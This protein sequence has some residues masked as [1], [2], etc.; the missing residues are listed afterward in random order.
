MR[1]GQQNRKG[2]S[3]ALLL[4]PICSAAILLLLLPA[5]LRSVHASCGQ[6]DDFRWNK[7]E[8]APAPPEPADNP[9][10]RVK[11]QLGRRL[12]YDKRLS[13]DGSLSCATCHQQSHAFT[14]GQPARLGVDGKLGIRNAMTLTNVAYLP[15]YTWANPLITSLECQMQVPLFGE[16]PVEMGMTGHER[17]LIAALAADPDYQQLF[18]SA[19]PDNSGAITL[20]HIFQAI[21]AFERTLLS[22]DSPY[23]RYRHGEPN[24]ISPAARR[25]EALFF[26]ERLECYHC[27]DGVTFT[28]NFVHQGQMIPEKGFHNT[29]L[30]NEDGHGAYKSWDH[31][32]RDVT[33]NAED[34]GAFRTT[35]LR[36]IAVTAPYMHDG[37]IATLDEVIRK[38]YAVKGRAALGPNGANPLRSEFIEGFQLSKSETRDLI[39][40]LRSLTDESFLHNPAFSDPFGEQQTPGETRI[41]HEVTRHAKAH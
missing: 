24:A 15:S 38:H 17:Q 23:D 25:G 18:A 7:P 13:R 20:P 8:W 28:D 16:H 21:A 31:G 29:G 14:D 19:F 9:M 34:E 39:A 40:F 1:S 10:S 6:A 3:G 36:N 2:N 22:F 12:F 30:Y 37:S 11:V 41:D 4:I 32:L 33:G 26:G 27:H 5:T 35:T